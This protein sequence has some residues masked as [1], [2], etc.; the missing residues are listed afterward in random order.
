MPT[1]DPLNY[2]KDL[3][4]IRGWAILFVLFYH[5]FPS[6]LKHGYIGVDIFFCLSG[7]LITAKLQSFQN[8]NLKDLIQFYQRRIVR[9]FPSLIFTLALTVLLAAFYLYR[10][11]YIPL[12]KEVK[13]AVLFITNFCNM[14]EASYFD[15]QAKKNFLLHT[16]S[17]AVEEQFYLL[18][19]L[20]FLVA[21][22]KTTIFFITLIV[23][24]ISFVTFYSGEFYSDSIKYYSPLHRFWQTGV[25]A[26]L[27]QVTS[28]KKYIFK[29]FS[30]LGFLFISL[31]LIADFKLLNTPVNS[32][33]A[34]L[35]AMI[36]I[37][38]QGHFANQFLLSQR[39]LV[40]LGKISYPLYLIHWPLL[41][42]SYYLNNYQYNISANL[43]L[44]LI[45]VLL[46]IF[47]YELIEKPSKRMS[48]KKSFTPLILIVSLAFL[49]FPTLH[50]NILSQGLVP[51]RQFQAISKASYDFQPTPLKS[52][53]KYIKFNG[54]LNQTI[55]GQGE[56]IIV[57][58]GD[59]H[60]GMYQHWFDEYFSINPES[61]NTVYVI[62]EP[63]CSLL[64]NMETTHKHCQKN[65]ENTYKF[66]FENSKKIDSII[67]SISYS[68]YLNNHLKD[69][70]YGYGKNFEIE[71]AKDFRQTITHLNSFTDTLYIL[72]PIPTD[73]YHINPNRYITRGVFTK[74]FD[75]DKV[76]ASQNYV[77]KHYNQIIND[78]YYFINDLVKEPKVQLIKTK[79][80]F[81]DSSGNINLINQYGDPYYWDGSHL[82]PF[83]IRKKANFL[84][85]TLK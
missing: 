38:S 17:L 71:F 69:Y 24:I 25:G 74:Y 29:G 68:L 33:F 78:K 54:T 11:E 57:L 50:I 81:L 65:T 28:Q 47:S 52:Q 41:V 21:R 32:L 76:K 19:P 20:L 36:F 31:A 59:S 75:Q 23:T 44:L 13:C 61:N 42:I 83:I 34:S 51:N 4:G 48:L 53:P 60:S 77:G 2:R 46:A 37:L 64:M 45:S 85:K 40:Y 9:L 15:L 56:N 72:E 7:F 43:W 49:I 6:T 1:Q 73:D 58:L 84:R 14:E 67:F 35:G 27:S 8:F 30:S 39:T 63:G 10:V 79:S 70:S 26:L 62:S 3:D 66:L 82:R 18:W 55:I 5:F 16:W 80:L 12:K 22:N